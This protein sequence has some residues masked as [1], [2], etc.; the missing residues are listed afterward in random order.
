MSC[1][2]RPSSSEM[3]TLT[4]EQVFK[5]L[6]LNY[7]AITVFVVVQ[8]IFHVLWQLAAGIPGFAL[9]DGDPGAGAFSNFMW[10][11]AIDLI[12]FGVGC[13]APLFRL[14]YVASGG[15]V[16][17]NVEWTR[18]WLLAYM[19]ILVVAGVSNI[20]HAG[21]LISDGAFCSSTLCKNNPWALWV[22]VALFAVLG[23]YEFTQTFFVYIYR[24][25]LKHALSKGKLESMQWKTRRK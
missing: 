7:V 4:E 6:N 16:E 14:N 17:K 20:I 18:A 2:A 10:W 23:V 24:S 25:N 3:A 19:F 15:V 12:C 11:S 22:A 21:L 8:G 1:C 9:Y 5:M 13:A